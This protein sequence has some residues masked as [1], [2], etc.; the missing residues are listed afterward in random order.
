[1]ELLGA[2]FTTQ[3]VLDLMVGGL[4]TGTAVGLL[5]VCLTLLYGRTRL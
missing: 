4:L 1:M 5:L 2:E 3:G